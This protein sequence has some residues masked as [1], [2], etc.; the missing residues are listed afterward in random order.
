LASKADIN[1]ANWANEN[2]HKTAAGMVLLKDSP[3]I[4]IFNDDN[5]NSY[6]IGVAV[7]PGSIT[8]EMKDKFEELAKPYGNP[9]TNNDAGTLQIMERAFSK[10]KRIASIAA[11]AE[12]L[13]GILKQLGVYLN[14]L[15]I[16]CGQG[17]CDTYSFVDGV[18]KPMH[19]ACEQQMIDQIIYEIEDNRI[20]GSYGLASLAAFGGALVG[21]VPSFISIY[22]FEYLIGLLF[23]LIPL[24]AAF[25]YQRARGVASKFMPF[26]VSVWSIIA[27]VLLVFVSLYFWEHQMWTASGDLLYFQQLYGFSGMMPVGMYI[28][29]TIDDIIHMDDFRREV[30]ADLGQVLLFCAIG[31]WVA[32]GYMT[33][34]NKAKIRE[35]QAQHEASKAMQKE[36]SE[37]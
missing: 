27:S 14:L 22:F 33:K 18:P 11:A 16:H 15:C 5:T 4:G 3:W 23:A 29:F 19:S 31:I 7:V 36:M 8:K 24:A 1:L 37:R 26:I 25:A 32:W 34:T 30:L 35:L 2:G 6:Y 10:N 17:S 12:A 13:P 21:A 20:N 28:E 9:L